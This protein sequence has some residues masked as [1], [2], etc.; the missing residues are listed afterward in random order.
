MPK[1]SDLLDITK[2]KKYRGRNIAF[3]TGNGTEFY[4]VGDNKFIKLNPSQFKTYDSQRDLIQVSEKG[5]FQ[6]SE[7]TGGQTSEFFKYFKPLAYEEAKKATVNFG[8]GDPNAPI[9]PFMKAFREGRAQGKTP[10]QIRQDYAQKQQRINE[11]KDKPIDTTKYYK[12]G[13]EIDPTK[14]VNLQPG[15]QEFKNYLQEQGITTKVPKR[16][17]AVDLTKPTDTSAIEKSAEMEKWS[18][19]VNEIYKTNPDAIA[20]EAFVDAVSRAARGTI[21]TK[22]EKQ[23]YGV[24]PDNP[25]ALVGLS[26]K[27]VM[28]RFGLLDKTEDLGVT[29]LEREGKTKEQTIKDLQAKVDSGGVLTDIDKQ[30]WDYATGG[31]P[32][33]IRAKP[34]TQTT[35]TENKQPVDPITEAYDSLISTKEEQIKDEINLDPLV[36]AKQQAEMAV[37]E[38]RQ[39]IADKKLLDA[40]TLEGISKNQPIPMSL[41][42]KQQSQYTQDQYIENLMNVQDYN[43]KV[44]LAQIAQGNLLEARNINKQIAN[45]KFELNKLIIDKLVTENQIDKQASDTLY[46]QAEYELN[47][48][49][50]G[51]TSLDNQDAINAA[52][53]QFGMSQ[54]WQDPVSK[55][56]YLK[57]KRN[58]D[59]K[60]WNVGNNIVAIDP[61]TG[62]IETVFEG[63]PDKQYNTIVADG[64]VWVVDEDFNKIKS[65]GSAYKGSSNVGASNTSDDGYT[66]TA[67]QR[68]DLKKY[69]MDSAN[70][71]TQARFVELTPTEM[72]LFWADYN[73]FMNSM[74]MEMEP[75]TY[76]SMWYDEY[77]RSLR[78]KEQTIKKNREEK[79]GGEKSNDERMAELY[80]ITVEEYRNNYK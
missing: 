25:Y 15:T 77:L 11:F 4:K 38:A 63:T 54:I 75:E 28:G 29:D 17:V 9:T 19:K 6:P 72:K 47:L 20:N 70:P 50:A 62:M 30:N 43:N 40:V 56:Y 68:Q 44:I 18:A 26:V 46:R 76:F 57:P 49:N 35:K 58:V 74:R 32:Y 78:E 36:K 66:F 34:L 52:I 73:E 45:D 5:G 65:L 55:T 1:I 24:D 16:D 37:E 8:M 10:E 2:L 21:A 12:N 80:G 60:Y 69:L 22:D 59:T 14:F 67:S 64:Q 33:P 39:T 51:Y 53:V 3:D 31:A 42:R 71:D 61:S 79:L 41:I 7:F 13:K 48:A 27:D 23:Q